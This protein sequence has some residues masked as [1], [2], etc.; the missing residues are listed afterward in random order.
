MK[1][2]HSSET[3][4]SA[5]VQGVPIIGHFPKRVNTVIAEVLMR[6]LN[7][8]KLTGL[9]AVLDANT[10][11]LG[12]AIHSLKKVHGWIIERDDLTVWTKDGRVE[13]VTEYTLPK[14]VIP[15]AMAAGA[16]EWMARVR[17]ERRKL[18]AKAA[19]AKRAA[20]ERNLARHDRK[21]AFA[22]LHGQQGLF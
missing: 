4:M 9:G 21:A 8:E 16:G 6:L 14:G 18:R 7:R 11:R 1:N 20:N 19:L 22:Q 12:S 2:A 15:L 5:P 3:E 10:T 17:V 13:D